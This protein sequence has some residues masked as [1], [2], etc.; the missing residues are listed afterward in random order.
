MKSELKEPIQDYGSEIILLDG[1]WDPTWNHNRGS[2]LYRYLRGVKDNIVI[3][4]RVHKG[5]EGSILTCLILEPT[6]L[7]LPRW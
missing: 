3:S 4:S 6:S 5:R 7:I 2:D 1:E